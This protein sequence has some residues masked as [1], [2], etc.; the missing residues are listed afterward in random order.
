MLCPRC[1][2]NNPAESAFC[3][4]CGSV[5]APL[6]GAAA[7]LAVPDSPA[8][9]PPVSAV[10]SQPALSF[11]AGAPAAQDDPTMHSDSNPS[12]QQEAQTPPAPSASEFV[13][14]GASTPQNTP[15]PGNFPQISS[16][17]VLPDA[18][19]Q[20]PVPGFV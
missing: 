7:D 14:F 11:Q 8:Q 13:D 20:F 19:Y 18:A 4:G 15:G 6:P 1:G 3:G 17:P 9:F 12:A 10:P 5:L 16:T 2:A